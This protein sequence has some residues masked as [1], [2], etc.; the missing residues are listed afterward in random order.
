M[1][2]N[3]FRAAALFLP[4]A[5]TLS[6]RAATPA[7][8]QPAPPL[9]FTQLIGAP[10]GTKTDWP[11]LH[12]KVV[13]LEFW[14]TWCAPCIAEIPH[15]NALAQSVASSNIQF[16]AIDDEDPAV[17][18][19]F[20][21]KKPITGWVGLVDSKSKLFEDYSAQLRPTTIVVDGEG[22]IASRIN[23]DLLNKDQLIALA[24]GKPVVFPEDKEAAIREKILAQAKTAAAD[25]DATAS[26][27][28]VRPLFELSI[29]PGDPDGQFSIMMHNRKDGNGYSYDVKD[30]PLPLLYQMIAGIPETRLIIHGPVPTAK[31]SL[32]ITLPGT[33]LADIAPATQL[34]LAAAG[35][36]KLSHAVTE[37]DAWVLEST[38]KAGSLLS[39][40]ASQH[41]SICFYNQMNSKLTMVK[42]SLDGLAPRLEEA[43]GGPVVNETNISGEFDA[44]LDLPKGDAQAIKAAL[45]TNLGLTLVRAKRKIDR[46]VLAPLP[47][48][49]PNPAPSV[50]AQPSDKPPLVPGQLI[51]T[52]AVPHKDQ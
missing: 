48:P 35:N 19:E 44:T 15:L 9:A 32:R 13:V 51:Q 45:E 23:A 7:V 39:V 42:T 3:R 36:M 24:S 40:S 12:G 52:I 18:K 17:V 29:W 37:E 14:A 38:P 1:Q 26:S 31:Y 20:L 21:A 47:T 27:T 2:L 28:T 30:G 16:I 34:A 50:A 49:A 5:F 41:G 4:L 6:A 43:L 22:R 11:S 46:I 25:P 33:S 10:E 8:G